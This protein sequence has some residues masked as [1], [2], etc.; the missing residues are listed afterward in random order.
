MHYILLQGYNNYSNRTYKRL[1]TVGEY[2]AAVSTYY[3]KVDKKVNFEINDGVNMT[4]VFNGSF[5]GEPNYLLLLS[6]TDSSIVSRWFIIHWDKIRGGQYQATLRRDLLADDYEAITT[7]PAFIEKGYVSGTDSAIFNK[8]NMTFNQ[9]K[10]S[11]KLLIDESKTSWIVGYIAKDH[12]ALSDKTF[13]VDTEVDMVVTSNF[14]DWSYAD[15]VDGTEHLTVNP[16]DTNQYVKMWLYYNNVWTEKNKCFSFNKST[17]SEYMENSRRDHF[18][19]HPDDWAA[20]PSNWKSYFDWDTIIQK[21]CLDNPSWITIARFNYVLSLVGKTI[22]FNDGFYKISLSMNYEQLGDTEWQ[23]SGNL[24][25]YIS[26]V[27]ANNFAPHGIESVDYYPVSYKMMLKHFIFT[28]QKVTDIAGTYKYSIPQTVKKLEDAPY[29]MFC[30]PYYHYKVT[31]N[32]R[33]QVSLDGSTYL[34]CDEDLMMSWAMSIS[35]EFADNLYDLQI[36]PY[37]PLSNWRGRSGTTNAAVWAV[38][39]TEHVDYEYLTE[40]ISGTTYSRGIVFFCD[41]STKEQ[42]LDSND[43]KITVNDYKISNETEFCRLCSPNYA[44]VFEFSPAKNNGVEGYTVR[45]TYKPYQ[46]FINVAPIFGRLYGQD[47]KD[48][49][50]LICSGE[51]SLPRVTD[52]WKQYQLQNKNYLLAFDRQ[53]ENMEVQ[54]GWQRTQN[55]VNVVTGTLQGGVSGAAAGGMAGGP[56]GAVAGAVV[57]TAASLGGG[58]ADLAMQDSLHNEAVDFSK[59]QFGFQLGNIKALPNTLNKVSSI[60]ANSKFFPFVE[61][62]SCTPEERVALENK[63]KYNGMSIGRIGQISDFL[64]PADTTYVKGQIIRLEGDFDAHTTNEI[65]NEFMK[66]WYI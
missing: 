40:T 2:K 49:R 36:L 55:I 19:L 60:V 11:E 9:I 66:G 18:R 65:A 50:G 63:I 23:N 20:I 29:K 39:K 52:L 16:T 14:S 47:F 37:C 33:Y 64:N 10:Q 25:T 59:D 32:P 17:S 45:Y 26:D 21:V 58:I 42:I 62:Y 61:F 46:P 43:Y 44:S 48:N 30:I 31:T 41:V 5:T 15:I 51:F 8:E 4:H 56:M 1:D 3:E 38:D 24:F 35:E 7:A 27:I 53:I 34:Y 12:A 22:Q 13:T 57:G 6:E 54:Y 28:K